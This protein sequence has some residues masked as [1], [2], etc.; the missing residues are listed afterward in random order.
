MHIQVTL[1]SY[2]KLHAIRTVILKA[3]Y[4]AAGAVTF[5]QALPVLSCTW[6]P[7]YLFL[8]ETLVSNPGA[9]NATRPANNVGFTS[10]PLFHFPFF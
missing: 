2:M 1:D 6:S 9:S 8:F 10:Q 4:C 7:F 3:L 5:W